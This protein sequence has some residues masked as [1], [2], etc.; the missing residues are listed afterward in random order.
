MDN[1]GTAE[2]AALEKEAQSRLSLLKKKS[3]LSDFKANLTAFKAAV[4]QLPFV[5]FP[6]QPNNKQSTSSLLSLP[7][8]L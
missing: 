1:K 8:F 5:Y 7:S 6:P 3:S 2:V 4:I